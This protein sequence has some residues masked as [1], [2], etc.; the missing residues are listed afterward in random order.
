MSVQLFPFGGLDL[1]VL[2]LVHQ[3]NILE[4]HAHTEDQA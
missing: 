3:N 1:K 2:Q 4:R